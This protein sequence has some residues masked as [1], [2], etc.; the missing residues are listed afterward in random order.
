MEDDDAYDVYEGRNTAKEL[1][2]DIIAIETNDKVRIKEALSHGW[3]LIHGI[4][5]YRKTD[6]VEQ[7]L[8]DI[9][10][11]AKLLSRDMCNGKLQ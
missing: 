9:D 1:I 8:S 7:R 11:L 5:I 4:K 10:M 3:T 6:I 2:E